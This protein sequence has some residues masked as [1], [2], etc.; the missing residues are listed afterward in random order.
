MCMHHFVI[1]LNSSLCRARSNW[2]A[3]KRIQQDRQWQRKHSYCDVNLN[4]GNITKNIYFK[5]KVNVRSNLNL[6]KHLFIYY[7][8]LLII[9]R[10]VGGWN[11]FWLI[12]GHH[13]ANIKRAKI[14]IK[15]KNIDYAEQWPLT[16]ILHT[17]YYH[18]GLLLLIH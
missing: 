8:T 10:V 12:L 18:I 2:L 7:L 1:I 3:E 16:V 15:G 14:S 17:P 5:L 4:K 9:C 6:F 11:L 13:R